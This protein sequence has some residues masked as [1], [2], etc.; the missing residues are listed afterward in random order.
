MKAVRLEGVGNIA[1]REVGKPAAGPDDLLVRIE[2]CGVCGTDRHLFHGEFPCMPPVTLGHEFSGIVEAIGTAV[3]GFS[4]GDRVTGDPNIACGSCPHCRAGR[5]NLCHNLIAIGIRRDGGFAEYVVLP[6]KQAFS[7]PKDLKPTHGAFCEP[8]GCCLHG[9]DLAQIRPGSSVAVLGGGV[10][11]LLTV[12]LARLAGATTIILSTRQASRR[13]LAEE[14][15]ATATVDPS[16]CDIIDTVVG[17]SGLMP[18]GVDVV[19]ECAGVRET[20]EQSM[21]LAKAG[22]TV[23]IVGVM[24]QGMKAEFE[25]FDLLF[26]ELRVLGSFLNPFMHRRAADLI[27]SGAIEI[28]KLISRHVTLEEA[29]AVIAN[30]PAPGEVKVLVVPR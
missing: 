16:A 22:G 9:L 18:G 17:A 21:R 29:T 3:S 24:P 28:D 5:F 27:A 2:A 4:V 13:A 26:R 1:L 30:P 8:L 23:V 11:G 20:V 14:L 6:Q 12:Q 25:P 15:G 19:F 10:I 7:L